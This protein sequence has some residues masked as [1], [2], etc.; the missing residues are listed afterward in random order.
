MQDNIIKRGEDIDKISA[1]NISELLTLEEASKIVSTLGTFLEHIEIISILFGL[2]M[3]ESILPYPKYLLVGA[4][5]KMVSH[6]HNQDNQKL[7]NALEETLCALISYTSDDEA[8]RRF[9]QKSSN[10]D[11]FGKIIPEL[12]KMQEDR[13]FRGY[14]VDNNLY[15]MSQERM[16]EI[17]NKW[18]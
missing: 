11:F 14:V 9:I 6:Y 8:I 5:N 13:V 17:R 4:I 15:K 1:S 2:N 18:K 7:V 12:K 10:E 3:P 16:E